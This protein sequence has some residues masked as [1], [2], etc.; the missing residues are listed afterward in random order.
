MADLSGMSDEEL[1]RIAGAAPAAA[2]PTAADMSNE[3]LERIAAQPEAKPVGAP[4]SALADTIKSGA[5]GL[6]RGTVG[7]P[8]I[9]G[10]AGALYDYA[11]NRAGHYGI[12]ALEA[13]GL[14]DPGTADRYEKLD[15]EALARAAAKDKGTRLQAEGKINYIFGMPF[16]TSTGMI[17]AADKG[18]NAVR[19]ET[20]SSL[21][22]GDKGPTP[23]DYKAQTT[24]GR[25]AQAIGELAPSAFLGPGTAAQKSTMTV[26]AGLGSEAARK[27]FEGTS[28]EVP[29]QIIG[30][31]GGGLGAGA[32]LAGA[33]ATTRGAAD[34]IRPI[35]NPESHA[36]RLLANALKDRPAAQAALDAP[37]E[38]VPGSMP[39][40]GQVTG[41]LGA[42]ALERDI[43]T[44]NPVPFKMREGEQNAARMAAFRGVQTEGAP[45]DVARFLRDQHNQI[46]AAHQINIDRYLT[47]AQRKAADLNGTGTPEFYGTRIGAE[48]TPKIEAARAQAAGQVGALGGTTPPEVLG[49]TMRDALQESRAAAKAQKDALYQA[50]DPEG[51]INIVAAPVRNRVMRM[52]DEFNMNSKPPDGEELQVFKIVA[53][54]PEVVPFQDLVALEQRVTAAMA[55]EN[56]RTP[57]WG[58]LSQVKSAIND[59]MDNGVRNQVERERSALARGAISAGNTIE[60]RAHALFGKWMDDSA[61]A[62]AGAPAS[63]P[64]LVPN[65]DEAAAQRLR[66]AK[67][68]H[69]ELKAT[70]D[71]GP[72]GAVLKDKFGRPTM[73]ESAVP[74]TAFIPGDKGL[75]T[76][77]A[78]TK[79]FGENEGAR[80]ALVDQAAASLRKAALREDG[81]L[82]PAKY[83]VWAK[84][85]AQAL[86]AIPDAADRFAQAARA[87][88]GMSQFAPF[89]PDL[90]P[91]TVPELFFHTGPSGFEGVQQLRRMVGDDRATQLL[92]DYVASKVRSAAMT[93]DGTI[94]PVKLAAFQS[95]RQYGNALRAFPELSERF[96]DAAKATQAVTEAALARKQALD[97]FQ[98]G[99]V[100]KVMGV[101]EP[102]DVVR[103]VGSIFGR[104]DAVA[105]MKRLAA[106][107]AKDPDAAE[108][109]KKSVMDHLLERL[110][111]QTEA[112]ASGEN[113]IK[114]NAFQEFLAKNRPVLEAAGLGKESID[115]LNAVA[116]DIARAKRTM[117]A[118]KFAGQSNTPQDAIAPMQE[119][120]RGIKESAGKLAAPLGLAAAG[121]HG[122]AAAAAISGLAKDFANAIR[123][124]GMGNVRASL[125]DAM[126]DPKR[127]A[128]MLRKAPTSTPMS[129][130]ERLRNAMLFV[131]MQSAIHAPNAADK[132]R[133]DPVYAPAE[134]NGGRIRRSDGGWLPLQVNNSESFMRPV[135]GEQAEDDAVGPSARAKMLDVA[136]RPQ[137]I[138]PGVV[139]SGGY[140][141]SDIDGAMRAPKQRGVYANVSAPI[142]HNDFGDPTLVGRASASKMGPSNQIGFGVEAPTAI[143]NF[144][145]DASRMKPKGGEADDRIMARFSRRF[146][147]GGR[148]GN[149]SDIA[150]DLIRQ[151]ERIKNET[152]RE[153]KPLLQ[154]PDE[155]IAAALAV[156]KK[157]IGGA[158]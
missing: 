82:D 158:V 51:S 151:H 122:A 8:G 65:F 99:A 93:A 40:T 85:H 57:T 139:V 133:E 33:Q 134:R 80:S 103:T 3:D 152:N 107:A 13:M 114:A 15:Q 25:Y 95:D 24:P 49:L 37:H 76:A 124:K 144:S 44:Q 21:V 118:T 61:L 39:T 9:I 140:R 14:A 5:A 91:S 147:N 116:A 86:R 117:N 132:R 77:Q 53:D 60:D 35:V 84:N 74:A 138:V 113:L 64:A 23:L 131:P 141:Q 87:S 52:A 71:E 109:L 7:L 104:N 81:T 98:A 47:E 20:L 4:P 126:L 101:S 12:K 127:A 55:A 94:D 70:F 156:A 120:A 135:T 59:A 17:A 11:A 31:L 22:T 68:A 32:T 88:D 96:G 97:D 66:D 46:D 62:P 105:Q 123:E 129:T 72:V 137:E 112:A 155:A 136:V 45:E 50:I 157:Q 43:A 36:S 28:A 111:S 56:G 106:E 90:A 148:I 154:Q 146:A 58:R 128:E 6:A 41:D 149:P 18:I 115:T 63:P 110:Q 27:Q 78:F 48:I 119:A 26:G 153:T 73:P 92:G 54:M 121:Q 38:L 1:E 30:G 29:A 89:R 16:P 125:R 83:A 100:G 19:P 108:G 145:I 10:D 75:Q 130:G 2:P 143:G 34:W 42:L 67:S 102:T 79:A 150:D 142:L 69:S